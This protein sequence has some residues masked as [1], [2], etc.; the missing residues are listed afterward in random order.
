MAGEVKLSTYCKSVIQAFNHPYFTNTIRNNGT[1]DVQEFQSRYQRFLDLVPTSASGRDG[2]GRGLTEKSKK[3]LLGRAGL[4]GYQ[5][6][7]DQLGEELGGKT[8]E[9]VV[10]E[11]VRHI[12]AVAFVVLKSYIH[13]GHVLDDFYLNDFQAVVTQGKL[14]ATRSDLDYISNLRKSLEAETK[15]LEAHAAEERV[16]E[17]ERRLRTEREEIESLKILRLP[18]KVE[19]ALRRA[20]IGLISQLEG[21]SDDDLS[22]IRLLGAKGITEI[23]RTLEEYHKRSKP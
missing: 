1:V 16:V 17:E 21:K 20:G 8:K 11:T 3:I 6:T 9:R 23:R 7:L 4:K 15:R 2:Y 14:K 19:N 22:K 13:R 5:K 10:G 12:Q 18:T